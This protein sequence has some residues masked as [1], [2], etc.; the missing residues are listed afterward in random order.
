MS[1]KTEDNFIGKETGVVNHFARDYGFIR[2]F[3]ESVTNDVFVYC[4][5]IDPNRTGF[6]ELV[7]GDKVKFELWKTIKGLQAKNVTLQGG[8]GLLTR[9]KDDNGTRH[10]SHSA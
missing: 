2:V 6:K 3:D 1:N 10:P 8:E 4:K 7:K 5:D 9:G